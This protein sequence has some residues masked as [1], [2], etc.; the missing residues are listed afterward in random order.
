M[1][2]TSKFTGADI[3]DGIEKA[4]SAVRRNG[5]SMT[6]PL[7]LHDVPTHE[8]GAATK[9]YVDDAEKAKAYADEKAEATLKAANAHAEEK[10][11]SALS[12]AKEHAN[13]I[14]PSTLPNPASL[15]FTGATNKGYDGSS[16]V[17][18][19]IPSVPSLDGYATEDFV[20]Q[21][22]KEIDIPSVEGLASE[23]FVARQIKEI[24]MPETLPNPSALTFT[25]SASGT[26]DGSSPKTV[27]IPSV[28]GLASEEYVD[29]AVGGINIP[30]RLPN[31]SAIKFTGA[32]DKTYDGSN[33]VEVEIP[34]VPESLKNPN[35]LTFTGAVSGTYDGSE[36]LEIN[37]PQGGSSPG[38]GSGLAHIMDG[39]ASGSVRTS[40]A[41]AESGTYA[42]GKNAFA[43][44]NFTKASGNFSHAEG[45]NTTASN[46]AAHAEG[47]GTIAAGEDQHVQGRY[48][49]E[50][51]DSKYLHIVGNG[52]SNSA[53][54]NAHTL[55][56]N[57]NAWFKG[58][59]FVGG[60]G[61][62]DS[63]AKE[64]GGSGASSWNDLTDRPFEEVTAEGYILSEK[65]W[66]INADV[67][68]AIITDKPAGSMI[69][70]K[71]YAV[72]Y[73]GTTYNCVAQDAGSEGIALGNMGAM[74]GGESTGEPFI[75]LGFAL[76]GSTNIGYLYYAVVVPLDGSEMVSF[77]VYGEITTIKKLDEKF[78]PEMPKNVYYIDVGVENGGYVVA[79]G[80]FAEVMAAYKAG[81]P[82][83]MRSTGVL[84]GGGVLCSVPASNAVC[85]VGIGSVGTDT[86]RIFSA[87]L[88]D[89]NTVQVMMGTITGNVITA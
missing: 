33:T 17:E 43:E 28:A 83:M 75:A 84:F 61:M 85:F 89:D 25:G 55:D 12:Q 58:K 6:G 87:T 11:N 62:D 29:Q 30:T 37:I 35:A 15:K 80:T 16:A 8:K 5:D 45:S 9:K 88:M 2:Y 86:I 79:S 1:S 7:L 77:A 36:A 72:T 60:T 66:E 23:D 70:G 78:L 46:Y 47:T 51:P 68:G 74:T 22:I 40:G 14:I 24:D 64:L 56:T 54:S 65:T 19:E 10:A 71:T 31:P 69:P 34:S 32:V 41:T 38:G 3:D 76:E 48:N 50:D 53:R 13:S 44:G 27:N 73:N 39:A 63:E 67:G 18:V 21:K 59:V 26:Y 20:E 49:I 4:Q 81:Q 82:V 52:D 42:L 57:G